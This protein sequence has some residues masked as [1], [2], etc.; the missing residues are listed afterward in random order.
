MSCNIEN[1]RF[2]SDS[3]RALDEIRE[4]QGMANSLSVFLGASAI[5]D[6]FGGNGALLSAYKIYSTDFQLLSDSMRSSSP[7][8]ARRVSDISTRMYMK[9]S[10]NHQEKLFWRCLYN[11]IR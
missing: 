1:I 7:I 10:L 5:L 8:L 3:K 4:L 6:I 11:E 2:G 9:P